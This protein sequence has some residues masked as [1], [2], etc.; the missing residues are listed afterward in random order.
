[1]CA[2]APRPGQVSNPGERV[3]ASLQSLDERKARNVGL[4]EFQAFTTNLAP[5]ATVTASSQNTGGGQTAVKA[6]DGYALG[7][8]AAAT[9]EWATLGGRAGAK[10]KLTWAQ[11]V[12]LSRSRV[13]G[14]TSCSKRSDWNIT[15]RPPRGRM[16]SNPP[17]T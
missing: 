1:M 12:K 6:V 7:Y 16:S 4:A 2:F 8:P 15:S 5:R 11:P 17:S 14:N 9:R 3:A 13:A 10:L